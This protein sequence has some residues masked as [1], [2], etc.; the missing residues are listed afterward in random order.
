M[1]RNDLFYNLKHCY[2]ATYIDINGNTQHLQSTSKN[3]IIENNPDIKEI[4]STQNFSHIQINNNPNLERIRFGQRAVMMLLITGNP[5][6]TFVQSI[7]VGLSVDI[8]ENPLLNHSELFVKFANAS[9]KV[10]PYINIHDFKDTCDETT[11]IE[12]VLFESNSPERSESPDFLKKTTN[13]YMVHYKYYDGKAYP[14]ITIPKGTILYTYTYIDEKTHI[15]DN[16]YNINEYANYEKEL[17]FF[18]SVPY[19]S[20]FGID[21]KYNY[22]HIVALTAEMRLLC[23]VSPAPQTMENMFDQDNNPS[24]NDCGE[25]YYDSSVTFP[26]ELFEHDLCISREF[27]EA[28]NVQGYINVDKEDS[29]SN[30]TVWDKNINNRDYSVFM[31]DYIMG[32]CVSSTFV[33]ESNYNNINRVFSI[34]TPANTLYGL[35]Q[36]VLCPIKTILFGEDHTPL[37][38]EYNSI[39]YKRIALK[40]R[41][42]FKNYNY[43]HID[44]CLIE[45]IKKTVEK[46]KTDIV[47]N[48][49]YH[50]FYLLNTHRDIDYDKWKWIEHIRFTDIDYLS[51]YENEVQGCAFETI[52]YHILKDGEQVWDR[53]IAGTRRKIRKKGTRRRAQQRSKN[54]WVFERSSFGMPIMYAK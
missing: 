51:D 28:M 26:C 47:Q 25:Q 38:D 5:K 3:L 11:D 17:K 18:Y 13:P 33:K 35:P 31:K 43:F 39:K 48:R 40:N 10:P 53:Q 16:L 52:G 44:S 37:Y 2:M 7:P 49:Q 1:Q 8:Y 42:F 54:S 6:L 32:S 50:L 15:L 4:I 19:G 23:M 41:F 14:I 12:N 24:T 22:C 29:I 27:M 34:E 46:F 9:S 21:G 45:D 30:G 20:K 36:I